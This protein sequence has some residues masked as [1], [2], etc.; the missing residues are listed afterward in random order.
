MTDAVPGNTY[1]LDAAEFAELR[2]LTGSWPARLATTAIP[3]T[4]RAT[5]TPASSPSTPPP[6]RSR[7]RAATVK[8]PTQHWRRSSDLSMYSLADARG[9]RCA[10][11]TGTR[12]PPR[13][14]TCSTCDGPHDA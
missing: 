8:L 7:S 6:W 9:G 14:A 1:D 11:R 2:R 13:W 12:S 10:N 3:S 4:V 5:G